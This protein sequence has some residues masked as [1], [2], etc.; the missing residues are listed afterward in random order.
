MLAGT[1][2]IATGKEP[3]G[4][5]VLVFGSVLLVLSIAEI[6]VSRHRS[7]RV[8]WGIGAWAGRLFA[9]AQLQPMAVAVMAQ[10]GVAAR[11]AGGRWM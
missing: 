6:L 1:L 4:R 2:L 8:G 3:D 11:G 9:I 10:G 5:A 7:A